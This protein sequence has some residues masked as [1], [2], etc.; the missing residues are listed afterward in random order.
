MKLENKLAIITGGAS[1]LGKGGVRALLEAGCRV[2][3]LDFNEAQGNAT[4]RELSL[5]YGKQAVKFFKVDTTSEEGV[6]DTIAG[7]VAHYGCY[8]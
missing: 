8:P 5:I 6:K 2:A 3:I 1:G 7:V 4:E